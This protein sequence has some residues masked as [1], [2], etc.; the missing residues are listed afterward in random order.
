MI[1]P[2]PPPLLLPSFLP[3]ILPS[4]SQSSSLSVLGESASSFL[5]RIF[6]AV[7]DAIFLSPVQ[8]ALTQMYVA[9]DDSMEGVSGKYYKPIASEGTISSTAADAALGARLWD[10]SLEQIRP[11]VSPTHTPSEVPTDTSTNMPPGTDQLQQ[12]QQH[13]AQQE[14]QGVLPDEDFVHDHS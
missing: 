12:Q 2:H 10:V 11:F 7:E 4:L 6:Q 9:V 13:H 1:P 3:S 14:E 5:G 8:G